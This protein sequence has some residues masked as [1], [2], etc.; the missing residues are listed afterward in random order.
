MNDKLILGIRRLHNKLQRR[1]ATKQTKMQTTSANYR[2]E[3]VLS[4]LEKAEQ[5]TPPDEVMQDILALSR[6]VTDSDNEAVAQ[7]NNVVFDMWNAWQNHQDFR[8]WIPT[9]HGWEGWITEVL[10]QE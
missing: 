1:L 9:V 3:I 2:R 8:I 5:V 10:K 6:Q 4:L 7:I